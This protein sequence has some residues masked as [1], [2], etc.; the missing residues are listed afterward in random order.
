MT[1]LS[2]HHQKCVGYSVLFAVLLN[3]LLPALAVHVATPDEVSPPAG[4]NALTYKEQVMHMLV[5]HHQV[6]VS[7]SLVVALVVALSVM[8][9]CKCVAKY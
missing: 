1:F 4:V 2:T 9:A 6:P 7:S 5:H 8:A 3:L